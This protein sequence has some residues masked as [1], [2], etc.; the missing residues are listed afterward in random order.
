MSKIKRSKHKICR[1]QGASVCGSASCP[2]HTKNYAPGQHGPTARSGIPS[3]F[4]K[5]LRAK[6][7]LKKHYGSITEKQFKRI[8]K[9]ASRRKGD[10]GENLIGLLESR[11]DALVYRAGLAPTMFAARQF[12]SHKHVKVNGQTVNIP[13]FRVSEGDLVELKNRMHQNSTVL[14]VAQTGRQAPEYITADTSK[15]TATLT[16]TPKLEDVPYPVVME[17][18]LIIEFY[19]R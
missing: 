12:V 18:N 13:S 15:F 7:Q 14:E 1:R 17:V 3:D 8:Y 19:S 11:L 6:Q 2:V 16:R 5:Q 9:E 4:G 10:T